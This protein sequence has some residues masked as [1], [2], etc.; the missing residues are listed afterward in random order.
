MPR[1]PLTLL[2]TMLRPHLLAALPLLTLAACSST[3]PETKLVRLTL[4]DRAQLELQLPRGWSAEP[5][6]G[7]GGRLTLVRLSSRGPDTVQ[8]RIAPRG[9]ETPRGPAMAA[10]A[11]QELAAS[12]ECEGVSAAVLERT[13]AGSG[14]QGVVAYC[15]RPRPAASASAAPSLTPTTAGT[16]VLPGLVAR[17]AMLGVSAEDEAAAWSLLQSL[18]VTRQPITY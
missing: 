6:M 4:E 2:P 16:L 9:A 15:T 14:G 3:P 12:K 10:L 13:I 17:F 8:L 1:R 7:N 5:T 18:Q 11:R